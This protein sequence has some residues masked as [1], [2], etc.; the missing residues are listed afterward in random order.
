MLV[1]SR[2][3]G[4]Q[5]VLPGGGIVITVTDI[6]GS[7]VKLG[8]QAPPEIAIQRAELLDQPSPATKV[9]GRKGRSI[10]SAVA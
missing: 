6:Q 1:L 9:A 2:K 3:V 8:I 10:L 4:E 5:I 7:R